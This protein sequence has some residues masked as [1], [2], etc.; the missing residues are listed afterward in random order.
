MESVK[1]MTQQDLHKSTIMFSLKGFNQNMPQDDTFLQFHRVV[2][3]VSK[4]TDV[5]VLMIWGL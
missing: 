4:D 1:I 5:L 3:V 2:F